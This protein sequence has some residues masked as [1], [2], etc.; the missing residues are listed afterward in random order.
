MS[1]MDSVKQQQ[2]IHLLLY[3]FCDTMELKDYQQHTMF[4]LKI[5]TSN[6]V[7]HENKAFFF[8]AAQ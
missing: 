5:K 6:G 3:L 2:Q 4:A 8:L 1:S 7:S